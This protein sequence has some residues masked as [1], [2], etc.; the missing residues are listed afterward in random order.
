MKRA[1]LMLLICIMC[2]CGCQN[3]QTGPT[4]SP[5]AIPSTTY[6]ELQ[7]AA[8]T[9]GTTDSKI[10]YSDDYGLIDPAPITEISAKSKDEFI[11]LTEKSEIDDKTRA[12]FANGVPLP[13]CEYDGESLSLYLEERGNYIYNDEGYAIGYNY[14][15]AYFDYKV[16]FE[17]PGEHDENCDTEH[18]LM[19]VEYCYRYNYKGTYLETSMHELQ[20]EVIDGQTVYLQQINYGTDYHRGRIYRIYPEE[21]AITWFEYPL[22]MEQDVKQIKMISVK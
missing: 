7:S 12:L 19:M 1:G 16:Y 20:S 2:L 11:S 4:I 15:M 14:N 22:C 9:P 6:G 21:N 18:A 17:L 13:D 5:D 8:P 3:T 10:H